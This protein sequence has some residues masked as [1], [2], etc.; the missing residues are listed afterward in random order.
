MN[1]KTLNTLLILG[2]TLLSRLPLHAQEAPVH[3]CIVQVKEGFQGG[4]T[5]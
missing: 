3:L 1:R 5:T 4:D 2:A